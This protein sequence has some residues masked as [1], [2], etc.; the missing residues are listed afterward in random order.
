MLESEFYSIVKAK[1]KKEGYDCVRI[2]TGTTEKGVPDVFVQGNGYDF[3]C[4]LKSENV[5]ALKKEKVKVHFR[6]GQLAWALRYAN[7]HDNH[8]HTLTLVRCSDCVLIIPMTKKNIFLI[9]DNFV[10]L[11]ICRV[12]YVNEYPYME[13]LGTTMR[14]TINQSI[15]DSCR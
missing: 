11:P 15:I 12:L 7:A 5:K 1:L 14:K 4:E 8:K 10:P 2:E 3:W 9:E 13:A 6:S